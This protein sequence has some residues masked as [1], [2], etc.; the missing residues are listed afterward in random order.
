MNDSK[1]INIVNT[2]TKSQLNGVCK[3]FTSNAHIYRY[4]NKR[5]YGRLSLHQQSKA[6]D[7]KFYRLPV[8]KNDIKKNIKVQTVFYGRDKYLRINFHGN[9]DCILMAH[10]LSR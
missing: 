4:F 1:I 6:N 9:K 3:N 2:V 8:N 7:F 5:N 10:L